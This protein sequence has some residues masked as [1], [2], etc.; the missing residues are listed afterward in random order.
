MS[1]KRASRPKHAEKN[2]A[3]RAYFRLLNECGVD[4]LFSASYFERA[5]FPTIDMIVGALRQR[6]SP[7]SPDHICTAMACI[8]SENARL[9]AL[10]RIRRANPELEMPDADKLARFFPKRNDAMRRALADQPADEPAAGA[11]LVSAQPALPVLRAAAEPAPR[12]RKRAS[13]LSHD[14]D[15]ASESP[16]V[17]PSESEWTPGES[18]G[19]DSDEVSAEPPHKRQKLADNTA[20]LMDFICHEVKRRV[21]AEMKR[22]GLGRKA[23]DSSAAAHARSNEERR[24]CK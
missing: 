15:D 5:A 4:H 17:S 1:S 21:R 11:I 8:N 13:S 16:D 24:R 7:H 14:S 3:R 18:S 20:H 10:Q 19:E 23:A 2:T 22:R 6:R 12:K 9:D